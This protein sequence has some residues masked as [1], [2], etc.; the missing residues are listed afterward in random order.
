MVRLFKYLDANSDGALSIQEL[1]TL[2]EAANLTYEERNSIA[3]SHDFEAKLR[4]E[5]DELFDKLD[6]NKS[7]YL[8]AEE[9][10]L[11]FK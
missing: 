9:L 7:G 3:F 10:V 6:Y 2:I 4:K 5:I 11:V 8:E 1:T